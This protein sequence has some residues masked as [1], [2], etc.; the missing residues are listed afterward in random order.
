MRP[1]AATILP[2][3]K[4]TPL[5]M[6]RRYLNLQ[7]AESTLKRGKAVECFLGGCEQDGCAGIKWLSI[8]G[9]GSRVSVS[10]LE[11][12]DLGDE[13]FLDIYE[14]GPLDPDLELE[15][16][17]EVISFAS[18]GQV[19]GYIEQGFTGSFE[20]LLNELMAQDEYADYL[21]RGR[22]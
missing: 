2:P 12:A 13:S 17:N 9:F 4:Q 18:F 3:I 22:K 11:V 15:E 7:E 1:L 5:T 8:R 14:F 21:S 19:I 10:V 16:G 20:R 6:S